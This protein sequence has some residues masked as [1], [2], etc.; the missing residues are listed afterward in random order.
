M[1]VLA[2]VIVASLGAGIGVNTTVFSWIQ[3]VVFNPLPGVADSGRLSFI[4]AVSGGGYPSSSWLEYRDLAARVQSFESLGASRMAP[5]Q[6]GETGR[7]ERAYAQLVS[8]NFFD[9]LGI[10]PA[11]GRLLTDADAA[12]PGQAPVAVISYDYWQANLGGTPDVLTRTLRANDVMLTVVGVAPREFQGSVLGLSFDIW[13]PATLAPALNRGSSELDDRRQRGYSVFGRLRPGVSEAQVQ[14]E[15]SAAMRD[16]AAMHPAS[17]TDVNAEVLTFFNAPRGP[18]RFFASALWFLQVVML[19]LLFTVCG[20]TANLVLARASARQRE[21]GVRLALGARPWRIA[22]LLVTE[23]V[24][25]ATAGTA[26]GVLIAMWGT[27]AL[28]AV[29][30]T[31][32]FPVKF[33]TQ[34]DLVTLMFAGGLGLLSALVFGVPAAAYLSE[35]DPMVALR[36]GSRGSGRSGL[37]STLMAVQVGLAVVVLIAAGLFYRG[38]E[39][40][41]VID[42][43]FQTDGVLLAAYDLSGRL[44]A[45]GVDQGR[46]ARVFA[47]R[48]LTDLRAIPGVEAAAIASAVPLDIH[49]LPTRPFQVEGRARADGQLERSS[50]NIVT[51]GYFATL[52]IRL[53]QGQDFSSLADTGPAPQAIVNEAFAREFLQGVEPLG[54]RLDSRGRQ[55]TIVGVVQTSTANAFGEAPTPML[56]LSYRDITPGAGE[57]HVRTFPGREEA[58]ATAVRGVIRNL[59]PELPV[60]NVRTMAEHIDRNLVLRRIPARMFVVLGPLL[61]LLAAIGIYGVVAF[62]VSQRAK[63]IAVRLA[64][65]ATSQRVV[66]GIVRDSL[67]PIWVGAITGW[68][69]AVFVDMHLVRGGVR[70]VPVL[71]AVPMVLMLVATVACW[72]PARRASSM[73]S[74][75]VLRQD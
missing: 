75:R 57:I 19:L 35:T 50:S 52:G 71:L 27:T 61:L 40:S 41:R 64:L 69:V 23:H 21:V 34:I 65:G 8:G 44:T 70:D 4:E 66:R 72:I 49:G 20:N 6:V 56:Y 16:L 32:A 54:H 7:T 73:A 33:Q 74:A 5:L 25:L 9:V 12:Q 22:S 14:A 18:Q 29:P 13:V 1:P 42:P 67:R 24:L 30:V 48:L 47:D 43:G 53:L 58:L 55:Y 46:A 28:R 17:N 63:E 62:S 2:A 26:L 15:V 68:V 31:G 39:D 59:D 37:R 45:G 36:A 10:R 51:P 38:F 3:A 60:Y 11:L